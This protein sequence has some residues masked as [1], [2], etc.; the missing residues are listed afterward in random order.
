MTRH[1][2]GEGDDAAGRST[3]PSGLIA[4]A[5][6]LG[7]LVPESRHPRFALNSINCRG[8]EVAVEAL[9][10]LRKPFCTL[11]MFGHEAVADNSGV[12]IVAP[13]S[14]QYATLLRDTVAGLLAT[15]RVYITDWIDARQVPLS[16]GSFDLDENIS[17]IIEFLRF[18]PP[19]LHVL[20]VCQS[21]VPALAA[22]A[23]LASEGAP[24]QPRS[25]ILMGGL[26]D[27]RINPTRIDRWAK[28]PAFRWLEQSVLAI[29]PPGFAGYLRPVYPAH[30][31]RLALLA[32]IGRHVEYGNDR[33]WQLRLYGDATLAELRF[34]RELLTLMDVPAELF[35]SNIR[36]VLQDHDLPRGGMAWEGQEVKPAAIRKTALMTIEGE[37]DDISGRG[38]TFAAHELCRSIPSDKRR[39]HLQR[40][41]GHFGMYAGRSWFTKVLPH[42][43]EFI[44]AQS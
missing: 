13:L 14:G 39:H 25:L 33:P 8:R 11:K 18:L 38:Q 23:L 16:A 42:V 1:A 35:L 44:Q 3:I 5:E 32:Y 43:R 20:A 10:L 24:D 30:I 29:V 37:F 31:Q 15:H 17:Y 7:C 19:K 2:R 34:C 4:A 9:D 22:I 40:G 26:I 36:A 12:L 28:T 21:A 6:L 41:V 27:T